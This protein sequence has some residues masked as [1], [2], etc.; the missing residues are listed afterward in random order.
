MPR[1]WD[2]VHAE[3]GPSNR[4]MV[5]KPVYDFRI[6][7]IAIDQNHH[8]VGFV[9]DRVGN[10]YPVVQSA[11]NLRQHWDKLLRGE[12]HNEP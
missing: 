1:Y 10:G 8:A 4:S 6:G 5:S 2:T 11:H 12:D 3:A 9:V 7:A